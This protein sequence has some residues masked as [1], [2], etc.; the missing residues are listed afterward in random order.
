MP[1]TP[2]ALGRIM[3]LTDWDG[4]D[5][6]GVTDSTAGIQRMLTRGGGGLC[7]VPPGTY[8]ISSTIL[9]GDAVGTGVFSTVAGMRFVGLSS[10]NFPGFPGLFPTTSPQNGV[11]FVW[12]GASG[13]TL[14]KIQGPMQGWGFEN[15]L[16]DCGGT[17]AGVGLMLV[18]AQMGRSAMLGFNGF[19]QQGILEMAYGSLTQGAYVANSMHNNYLGMHFS[20]PTG[21]EAW[22]FDSWGGVTNSCYEDITNLLIAFTGSN[23]TGVRF[24]ACDSIRIANMHCFQTGGTGPVN[25]PVI[26]DY[27]NSV[28]NLWPT[29]NVLFSIDPGINNDPG[30]ANIGSPSGSLPQNNQIVGF[31]KA[32]GA[33]TPSLSGLTIVS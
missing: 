24:R 27:A 5:P 8:G 25:K 17:A 16:F 20:V 10:L 1:L 28:T 4:I 19:T 12:K 31:S 14:W 11:K 9:Q 13:G 6:T 26:W 21:G 2:S 33:T 15:I 7:G 3:L 32:N 18:A 30:M 29:A 22:R 23:G